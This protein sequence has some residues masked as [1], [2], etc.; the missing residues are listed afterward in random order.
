MTSTSRWTA[1]HL[2]IHPGNALASTFASRREVDWAWAGVE[3]GRVAGHSIDVRR[4]ATTM[5]ACH[6]HD[7]N[8]SPT[9][10]LPRPDLSPGP[11]AGLLPDP[12]ADSPIAPPR[13]RSSNRICTRRP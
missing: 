1:V 12:P 10:P 4:A 2:D 8:H 6:R 7:T 11:A 5:R 13:P 3:A 9:E